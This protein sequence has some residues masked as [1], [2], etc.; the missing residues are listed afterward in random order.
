MERPVNL[1]STMKKISCQIH[2]DFGQSGVVSTL[3]RFGRGAIRNYRWFSR[4]ICAC[5]KL[6]H[7]VTP[8]SHALDFWVYFVGC[9][10]QPWCLICIKGNPTRICIIR[11]HFNGAVR[12]HCSS[13]PFSVKLGL[14]SIITCFHWNR[15]SIWDMYILGGSPGMPVVITCFLFHC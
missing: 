9:V 3:Y 12:V 13:S 6:Q 2:F 5:W 8:N 1:V 15:W 4:E 7:P 14:M 11:L 10:S